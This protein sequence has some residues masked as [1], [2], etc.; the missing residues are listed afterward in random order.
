MQKKIRVGA[1]SYLNT[2]PLIYGF[3]QGL[4]SDQI[5]LTLDY[6][7]RLATALQKKEIDIALLPVASI[8]RIPDAEVISDYCIGA[9]G[10]VASVCIYSEVPIDEIQSIYLDYQSQTSV[11]LTK[12]LLREHWQTRPMLME[13][14][15]NYISEIKGKTAGLIIGDRALENY[16]KFPYRY[17]L[18]VA[19]HEYTQLPF[20]FATWI[21]AVPLSDEFKAEF[22]RTTGM[23]VEAIDRIIADTPYPAYDIETYYKKNINYHLDDEKKKA[24]TLFMKLTETN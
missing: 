11:A 4:L 5:E 16:N 6:P 3:Q 15:E 1:V 2:K 20:V 24:M 7:A 8:Q 21:S 18:S 10:E 23:G 12:I 14:N 19:W 17:D 22:N 13:A 9:L